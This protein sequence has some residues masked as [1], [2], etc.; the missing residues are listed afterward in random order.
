M[1]YFY[2]NK[3]INSINN[4]NPSRSLIRSKNDNL[5]G[6]SKRRI[7]LRTIIMF[8]KFFAFTKWIKMLK[9]I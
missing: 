7:V 1:N 9:L 4:A 8:T 3:T 2:L 5:R 6:A